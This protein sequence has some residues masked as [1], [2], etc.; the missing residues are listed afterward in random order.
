M[1]YRKL[2]V[3]S[4]SNLSRSRRLDG[5]CGVAGSRLKTKPPLPYKGSSPHR[6]PF[7]GIHKRTGYHPGPSL[8]WWRVLRLAGASL[9]DMTNHSATPFLRVT[10]RKAHPSQPAATQR[11]EIIGIPILSSQKAMIDLG[12]SSHKCRFLL[13]F[14]SD[15][16]AC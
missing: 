9:T 2:E 1:R 15:P 14:A 10:I 4:C 3:M 16:M 8:Q 7:W 11:L 5:V 6:F 13:N 12:M